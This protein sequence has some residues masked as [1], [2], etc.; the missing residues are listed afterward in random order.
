MNRNLKMDYNHTVA[1]KSL[2]QAKN[3][4]PY[5]KDGF[6]FEIEKKGI[7]VNQSTSK[8]TSFSWC[9]FVLQL[10]LHVKVIS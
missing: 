6:C 2:R 8:V 10:I 9:L 7:T 5:A 4:P 1:R 3:S